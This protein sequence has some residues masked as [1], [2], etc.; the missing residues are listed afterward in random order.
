MSA[1]PEQ[2]LIERY[3]AAYNAFDIDGMLAPLAPHVRFENWH[4][5]EMT[6]SSDGIA[7]FRALAEQARAMFSQREQRIAELAAHGSMVLAII[8]W[9]GTLAVDVPDGP[10]AGTALEL[11]GES[12]F[13]FEDGRIASIV[14]R[15]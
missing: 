15:S 3:L 4:G 11:R 8:E 14:D 5:G 10:P 12:L 6:V 13:G 7:A 9:R 1:T 2:V